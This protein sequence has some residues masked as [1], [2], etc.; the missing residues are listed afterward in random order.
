M[1]VL[2]HCRICPKRSGRVDILFDERYLFRCQCAFSPPDRTHDRGGGDA[3]QK[4][5]KASH[6]HSFPC[7]EFLSTSKTSVSAN[8]QPPNSRHRHNL[9]FFFHSFFTQLVQVGKAKHK[10]SPHFFLAHLF[11]LSCC[12]RHTFLTLHHFYTSFLYLFLYSLSRPF[13]A[14]S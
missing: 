5:K 11:L 8:N 4:S 10:S 2:D 9:D 6:L 13:L 14:L 1:W 12:Y 7:R 3:N